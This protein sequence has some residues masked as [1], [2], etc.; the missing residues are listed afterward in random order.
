[1]QNS[2]TSFVKQLSQKLAASGR[3]LTLTLHAPNS[4]YKGYD[5]AASSK[6]ADKI[7]IMAYGYGKTPEPVNSVN[8]AIKNAV[9]KVPASKLVLGISVPT[10]TSDSLPD[11]VEIAKK[12]GLNGIAIWRLGLVTPQMWNMLR[13]SVIPIK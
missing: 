12:Y 10:E 6:S 1:M 8:Q 5:Y 13:T 2:F 3:S 9:S 4:A 7:I 11:K